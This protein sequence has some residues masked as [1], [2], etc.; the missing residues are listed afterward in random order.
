MGAPHS[1]RLTLTCKYWP[2]IYFCKLKTWL[3]ARIGQHRLKGLT[4]L[5]VFKNII[6]FI[7]ETIN[8]FAKMKK[9]IWNLLFDYLPTICFLL[10][11]LLN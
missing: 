3:R 7:D 1:L 9:E 11:Y 5:H 10:R 6:V 4:L 8:K 2:K